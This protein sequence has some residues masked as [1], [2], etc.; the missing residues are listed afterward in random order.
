LGTVRQVTTSTDSH[1]SS[2]QPWDPAPDSAEI[3]AATARLLDTTHTLSDADVWAPSGLPGWSRGHVLAHVAGNADSLV[4]L[5]TWAATGV[6]HP[7]YPSREA[8]DAAIEAGA[9]DPTGRQDPRLPT[10]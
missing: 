8:R 9:G 5:L 10:S 3:A 6:E 7:Q 4:T 2:A 1:P